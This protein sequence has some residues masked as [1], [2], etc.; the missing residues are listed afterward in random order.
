MYRLGAANALR[1]RL[2]NMPDGADK[3]KAAFGAPATREKVA[4]M[5]RGDPKGHARFMEYLRNESRMFETR[6]KSLGGSATQERLAIAGDVDSAVGDFGAAA[7]QAG[8]GRAREAITT[9][10]RTLQKANPEKRAAVMNEARKVLFNPDPEA[11]RAFMRRAE[12]ANLTIGQREEIASA[13]IRALP[14]AVIETAIS[15]Q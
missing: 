5:M 3:A 6:S 2:A 9:I 14:R 7:I 15:A 13:L 11:L 12:Q 8:T 10:W 4:A 1:D